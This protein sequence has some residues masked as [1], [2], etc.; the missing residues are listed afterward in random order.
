MKTEIFLQK[1][2][3]SG[4]KSLA[5]AQRACWP[6]SASHDVLGGFG[7]AA[8]HRLRTSEL[9]CMAKHSRLSV[10]R[11]L[12]LEIWVPSHLCASE[13]N[14]YKIRPMAATLQYCVDRSSSSVCLPAQHRKNACRGYDLSQTWVQTGA[15]PVG[16]THP[17][18][19]GSKLKRLDRDGQ[20]AIG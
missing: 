16:S 4:S 15:K 17:A 10:N 5:G 3:D 8:P 2:L 12:L 18:S 7:T 13:N 20:L 9:M 11:A 6:D 1:W 19:F 14:K